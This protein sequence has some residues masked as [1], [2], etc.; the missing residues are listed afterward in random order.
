MLFLNVLFI[1]ESKKKV[2]VSKTIKLHNSF[3]TEW[4][5][6]DHVPLKTGVMADESSVVCHR[7]Q[8]YFISILK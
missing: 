6:K 3:E 1:K 5:L 2:S 8:L 7:N 4:F